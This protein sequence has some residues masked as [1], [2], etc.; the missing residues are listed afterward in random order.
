MIC[1]LLL[2]DGFFWS[3]L[4]RS[5]LAAFPLF[6]A[7]FHLSITSCW[8][9]GFTMI[10]P[11]FSFPPGT[12]LAYGGSTVPT[13]WLDCDGSAISRTTYVALFAAVSTTWGNGNGS[14]TFNIPDLRGRSLIGAGTGSGLTARTLAATGGSETHVL[15]TGELPAHSHTLGGAAYVYVGSGGT[16]NWGVS[17]GGNNAANIDSSTT[18]TGSGTSHNN[19]QPFAVVKWIIK[20]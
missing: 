18:N 13:G 19:M 3:I 1:R 2:R 15:A 8:L 9:L 6:R 14:T 7:A 11:I 16:Y 20:M 5:F 4:L 17:G 12:L 10:T